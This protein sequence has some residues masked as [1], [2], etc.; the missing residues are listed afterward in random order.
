MKS[1]INDV[2]KMLGGMK[3]FSC[4]VRF[5]QFWNEYCVFICG[6]AVRSMTRE[7]LLHVKSSWGRVIERP[8]NHGI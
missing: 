8:K 2:G 4:R 5:V 1:R 7:N 3:V 6:V